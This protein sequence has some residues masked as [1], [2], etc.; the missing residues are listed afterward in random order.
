MH[1]VRVHR[2]RSAADMGNDGVHHLAEIFGSFRPGFPGHDELNVE[3]QFAQPSLQL[4]ARQTFFTEIIVERL[5]F[6]LQRAGK[7]R[8]CSVTR[9]SGFA[10][11]L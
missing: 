2:A 9:N 7:F 8:K 3:I 1:F 6:H 5:G 11:P 4:V 10:Q